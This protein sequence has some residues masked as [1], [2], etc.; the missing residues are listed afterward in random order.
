MIR[1][2]RSS[3]SVLLAG[4]LLLVG[5]LFPRAVAFVRTTGRASSPFERGERALG[6]GRFFQA[7]IAFRQAL[8][9]PD[10]D[11]ALGRLGQLALLRGDE[12]E[13]LERLRAAVQLR[14]DDVTSWACLGWLEWRR[15]AIELAEQAWNQG[16]R[17]DGHFLVHGLKGEAAYRRRAMPEAREEFRALL[18]EDAPAS[19][20]AWA[21]L[22]LG[23]LDAPTDP[24]SALA[25]WR[26]ALEVEAAREVPWSPSPELIFQRP[27]GEAS[28]HAEELAGFLETLRARGDEEPILALAQL[29][30]GQQD[31]C[32]A[33]SL[34]EELA[35]GT[36]VPR[37]EA[38]LGYARILCG[39]AEAG[40]RALHSARTRASDDPFVRQLLARAYL[41]RGWPRAARYELDQARELSPKNP[42]IALDL[43]RV[44]QEEGSY[45]E[46]DAWF[47]EAW[48]QA[49]GSTD[50]PFVALVRARFYLETGW[51]VCE[52]GKDAM[53]AL[54][55]SL[56]DEPET[57]RVYG[58]WLV[59]CGQPEQAIQVLERAVQSDTAS[60]DA[61]DALGE[62]YLAGGD[63]RAAARAF[64]EAADREPWRAASCRARAWL[65]AQAASFL[66]FP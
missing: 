2:P 8:F 47:S 20:R 35:E 30:V 36:A 44:A 31:G 22:R 27:A 12:N 46:A 16:M 63:R 45:E 59:L 1:L 38:S 32:G 11:R 34:L 56:P 24:A 49:Q 14:P 43:A 53:A 39:E 15:G 64:L 66:P 4:F 23:T 5:L 58:R 65:L 28:R 25:H 33:A 3:R 18:S 13:A 54:L 17:Y 6:E 37:V 9:S 51:S 26:A 29:L 62:A 7:E 19:W 61:Y 21:H 42:L 10:R 50:E 52:R 41:E 60:A 40:L 55:L 48:E 57:L